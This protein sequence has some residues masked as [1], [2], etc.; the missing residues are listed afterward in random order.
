MSVSFSWVLNTCPRACPYDQIFLFFCPPPYNTVNL[1]FPVSSLTYELAGTFKLSSE[2]KSHKWFSNPV[3][4]AIEW[5]HLDLISV[6]FLFLIVCYQVTGTEMV[7]IRLAHLKSQEDL[8]GFNL[9]MTIKYF[10]FYLRN[11]LGFLVKSLAPLS[12]KR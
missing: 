4:P 1:P 11:V 12:L 2:M 7:I 8:L 6:R 10:F 5:V 3:L 9:T